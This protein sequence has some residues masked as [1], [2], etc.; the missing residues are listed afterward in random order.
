MPA[1]RTKRTMTTF[2]GEML[3]ETFVDATGTPVTTNH[4]YIPDA[5][6][7]VVGLIAD[8]STI[9]DTFEYWPYGEVRTRTGTYSTPFQ[10]G[11]SVGYYSDLIA[12]SSA[13]LGDQFAYPISDGTRNGWTDASGGTTNLYQSIDDPYGSPDDSNYI[14]RTPGA[15]YIAMNFPIGSTI[16]DPGSNVGF[17]LNWRYS[18][19]AATGLFNHMD[20]KIQLLQGAT[21]IAT[22][23][24]IDLANTAFTD[25][26]YPLTAAEAASITDFSNLSI[27]ISASQNDDGNAPNTMRISSACFEV[28]P[29]V[30]PR[31]Y[32]RARHLRP[33]LGRWMTVDPLWPREQPYRYVQNSPSNDV[34]P[35]GLQLLS[36]YAA[37]VIAQQQK[38]SDF[39]KLQQQIFL[40]EQRDQATLWG[41]DAQAMMQQFMQQQ[42]QERSATYWQPNFTVT[43]KSTYVN[44]KV[45]SVDTKDYPLHGPEGKIYTP[46]AVIGYWQKRILGGALH[47]K[48]AA[49]QTCLE[50]T[51]N[52]IDISCVPLNKPRLDCI[53]NFLRHGLVHLIDTDPLPGA[54]GLTTMN[55]PPHLPGFSGYIEINVT[56][57]SQ[58]FDPRITTAGGVFLHEVLHACGM[59]HSHS[60]SL[61]VGYTDVIHTKGKRCDQK[62]YIGDACN[63]IAVC[64]IL[65]VVEN[66]RGNCKQRIQNYY[67][68]GL[69]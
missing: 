16:T 8:G 23:E 1:Y 10:F 14:K 2:A 52:A 36:I 33:D 12:D 58:S 17:K 38:G 20:L 65:Q 32:V 42:R 53:D 41:P 69:S 30:G 59:D 26:S 15:F 39:Q 67:G 22:C 21:I 68:Q 31:Q 5:L 55:R 57:A 35:T 45:G 6:G 9:S 7:S 25:D 61:E 47:H 4:D 19:A 13:Y 24:R 50:E 18:L 43:G 46:G 3:G 29:V 54:A 63:N 28:S 56:A 48:Q 37:Q 44:P 49:L 27:T 11:G 40:D 34:D 66:Y 51:A 64:C 60:K 62:T